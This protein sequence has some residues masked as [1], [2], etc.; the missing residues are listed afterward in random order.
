MSGRKCSLIWSLKDRQ[1]IHRQRRG[2]GRCRQREQH[3]QNN[4]RQKEARAVGLVCILAWPKYR[5]FRATET[6]KSFRSGFIALNTRWK[7]VP[8]LIWQPAWKA[9]TLKPAFVLPSKRIHPA[10]PTSHSAPESALKV[11]PAQEP[12][13]PAPGQLSPRSPFLSQLTW[14]SLPLASGSSQGFYFKT[15]VWFAVKRILKSTWLLLPETGNKSRATPA[16]E[17]SREVSGP[18]DVLDA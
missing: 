2:Q 8:I 4:R 17:I 5:G 10:S 13:L 7:I 14:W 1:D 3:E 12:P 15:L 11:A 6:W 9:F 16:C 18:L